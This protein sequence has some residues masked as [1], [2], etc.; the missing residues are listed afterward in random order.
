[1]DSM[2]LDVS[3]LPEGMLNEGDFVEL[4][5]P[6]QSLEAVAAAAETIAYEVLTGLGR[7]FAR[8]YLTQEA[9]VEIDA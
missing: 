7:R 8:T 2:T 1:M 6:H 4:I 3:G 9:R 5:G